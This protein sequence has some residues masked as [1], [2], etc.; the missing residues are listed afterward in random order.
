MATSLLVISDREP[1]AWMLRTSSFAIPVGRAS[2]A[3]RVGD[4]LLLYT[5]RGCY[6]NPTRDRGLVMGAARVVSEATALAEPVRFG[7][8]EFGIG[9]GLEIDGV[10]PVHTG[11]ELGGLQGRLELLPTAGPWSYRM[12]R[13]L[14]RVSERD[15]KV[16]RELLEPMLHPV[17]D[18]LAGYEQAARVTRETT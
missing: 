13:T 1:L 12:R 8:R 18:V 5:T 4:S 6:R 9:L 10:C 3:P 14:V 15:E 17:G 11:V 7:D 16:I 2:S